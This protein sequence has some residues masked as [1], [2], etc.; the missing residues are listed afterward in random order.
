[1]H[2]SNESVTAEPS[3]VALPTSTGAWSITVLILW[4]QSSRCSNFGNIPV[5][6]VEEGVCAYSRV[7]AL[8]RT[9]RHTPGLAPICVSE[10]CAVFST[11]RAARRPVTG[12]SAAPDP[13]TH[14]RN[15]PLSSQK[16]CPV[17]NNIDFPV[18]SIPKEASGRLG[19][20]G[21]S[22]SRARGAGMAQQQALTDSSRTDKNHWRD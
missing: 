11:L 9:P 17:M 21:S 10:H 18:F 14:I 15:V 2:V 1:M 13:E 5:W 16:K 4:T 19:G 8:S 22:G 12:A 3:H 20:Q 6:T 7:H